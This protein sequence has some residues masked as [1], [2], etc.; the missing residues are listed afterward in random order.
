MQGELGSAVPISAAACHRTAPAGDTKPLLCLI[1]M[2]KQS[3]L[4][5]DRLGT[6]VRN[7]QTTSKRI[8]K[9][10]CN[11]PP[12]QQSNQSKQEQEWETGGDRHT[13][14]ALSS[15]TAATKRSGAHAGAPLASLW[16][17][18]VLFSALW[19]FSPFVLAMQ[20]LAALLVRAVH[21]QPSVPNSIP[22]RLAFA[23]VKMMQIESELRSVVRCV[24]VFVSSGVSD[25][26][27]D[28][29]HAAADATN[30]PGGLRLYGPPPLQNKHLQ[31]HPSICVGC[32]TGVPVLSMC[33]LRLL[34]SPPGAPR[35]SPP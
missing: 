6:N 11:P 7:P 23:I 18:T 19:Q 8:F 31:S 30:R 34:C 16:L 3:T 22:S 33:S 13:D 14:S 9:Q 2:L 25:P 20:S 10:C 15:A 28:G 1:F 4:C 5:L 32:R 27:S 29:P 35:C 24:R 21:R 17:S 12:W 26:R